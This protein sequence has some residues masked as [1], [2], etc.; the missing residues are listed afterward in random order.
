[1]QIEPM[2]FGMASQ[3]AEQRLAEFK[4]KEE[5]CVPRFPDNLENLQCLPFCFPS[6]CLPFNIQAT[7]ELLQ[8]E[9][10]SDRHRIH[11]PPSGCNTAR[12][13]ERYER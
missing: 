7:P 3:V 6:S 11:A 1:M 10:F 8:N 5:S 9:D 13:K 4:G 2:S 12:K